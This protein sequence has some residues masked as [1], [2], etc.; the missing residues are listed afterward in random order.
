[1]LPLKGFFVFRVLVL[2][3]VDARCP[4]VT[5]GLSRGT[6]LF[7]AATHRTFAPAL[8]LGPLVGQ[9]LDLARLLHVLKG[10]EGLGQDLSLHL[11]FVFLACGVTEGKVEEYAAR[12]SH[13]AAD[14]ECT[15]E[16]NR[17]DPGF[18]KG[19]GDQ[20]DRLM[21]DGSDRHQQGDVGALVT[22]LFHDLR[23]EFFLHASRGI[24]PTHEG[25]RV[26]RKAPQSLFGN[27]AP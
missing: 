10:R 20:S 18:F 23:C 7:S 15:G 21:A 13:R 6:F 27:Q 11:V 17:G 25:D 16:N 3:N 9:L 19:S 2:R 5:V 8:V 12:G 26:R 4:G 24:D 22:H 1:M 14:T